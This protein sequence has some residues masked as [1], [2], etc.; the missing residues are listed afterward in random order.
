MD[1]LGSANMWNVITTAWWENDGNQTFERHIIDNHF[2]QPL[3][4]CAVDINSDGEMDVLSVSKT[5]NAVAWWMNDGDQN[6]TKY[7]IDENFIN[8]NKA[9]PVDLDSDGD[10][11]ILGASF[12]NESIYETGLVA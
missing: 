11:D 2:R 7:I 3:Y 6:F 10:I 12:G 4:V 5:G 1:V 8:A 9:Y